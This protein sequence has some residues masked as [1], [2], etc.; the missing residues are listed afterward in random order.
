MTKIKIMIVDDI[1]LVREGIR[2]L[3]N[4]VVDFEV[5]GEAANGKEA[6]EMAKKLL[7]DVV[8]MD[9]AMPVMTGCK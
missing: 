5:V 4:Q 1:T 9:L 3:L 6:L 8:L 2:S 7:P